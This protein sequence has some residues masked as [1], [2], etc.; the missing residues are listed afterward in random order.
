MLL[1]V[2]SV[3]SQQMFI[4]CL[5]IKFCFEPSLHLV[6][7]P[8]VTFRIKEEQAIVH[9]LGLINHRGTNII[10]YISHNVWQQPFCGFSF[11]RYN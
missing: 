10:K 4:L 6:N 7:T 2:S 1:F 5:Y 3:P 8:L 9:G 11:S